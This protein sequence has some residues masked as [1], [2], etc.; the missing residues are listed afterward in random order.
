MSSVGPAVRLRKQKCPTCG[1]K[2]DAASLIGSPEQ[3]GEW[4]P[5][6]GDVTACMYCGEFLEFSETMR[7]RKASIANLAELTDEQRYNLGLVRE[8]AKAQA[9]H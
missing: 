4:M 3:P 7:I 1:S 9:K 8:F 6:A 2:L 5:S